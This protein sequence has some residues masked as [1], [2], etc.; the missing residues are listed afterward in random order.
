MIGRSANCVWLLLLSAAA[1]SY[2][3]S[4]AECAALLDCLSCTAGN[5]QLSVGRTGCEWSS[6]SGASSEVCVARSVRHSPVHITYADA[7]AMPTPLPKQDGDDDVDSN[8][9]NWMGVAMPAIKD[10]SLLDLSLPG[11]HDSLT[12]DLSLTT[13]DGGIDDQGAYFLC[14]A[15]LCVWVTCLVSCVTC[16]V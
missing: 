15:M 2:A 6:G 7:C 14:H 8:L 13:S 11:T 4:D 10:L 3:T 1:T 9:A 5:S 12:Y 16:D